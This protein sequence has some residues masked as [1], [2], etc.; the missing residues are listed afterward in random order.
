MSQFKQSRGTR[1][2][3]D[4]A[5]EPEQIRILYVEDDPTFADLGITCLEDENDRFSITTT[6]DAATGLELL[7]ED[8]DCIISDYLDTARESRPS[9]EGRV[10]RRTVGTED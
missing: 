2:R 3:S 7:T 5:E 6:T 10:F 1:F 8:I 4:V 9:R